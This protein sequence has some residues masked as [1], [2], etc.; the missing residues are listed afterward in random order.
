MNYVRTLKVRAIE[1]MPSLW[2]IKGGYPSV[3]EALN[4]PGVPR[5]MM[6]R[7][8]YARLLSGYMQKIELTSTNNNLGFMSP[9][10][11]KP[12]VYLGLQACLEL[13]V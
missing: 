13:K 1:N 2:Q 6:V 11:F 12:G 8:P 9:P 10:G 4:S 7:N 5:F 3:V